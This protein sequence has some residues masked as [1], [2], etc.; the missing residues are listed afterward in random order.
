MPPD[1]G[2]FTTYAPDEMDY[3]WNDTVDY[4]CIHG[5]NYSTGDLHRKCDHDKTWS[6]VTPVCI[7][8]Y[9]E[10]YQ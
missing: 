5:Y 4:T 3:I 9:G 8:K 10:S 2:T 1:N 7:S 6:G